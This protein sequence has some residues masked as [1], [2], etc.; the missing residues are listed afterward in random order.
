MQTSTPFEKF[1]TVV[2]QVL[3]VSSEEMQ[4]RKLN[5]AQGVDA[6]PKRRGPKRGSKRKPKQSSVSSDLGG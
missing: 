3:S 4:R 2:S 5:I 6:N 1:S